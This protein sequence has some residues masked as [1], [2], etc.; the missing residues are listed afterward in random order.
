MEE[1][2]NG[3]GAPLRQHRLME[4]PALRDLLARLTA[5]AHRH[6]GSLTIEQVGDEWT[7][8]LSNRGRDVIAVRDETLDSALAR[9]WAAVA[10]AGTDA[11]PQRTNPCGQGRVV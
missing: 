1:T 11:F 9:L 4:R 6:D 3:G 5:E 10:A 8:A 7:A 2:G